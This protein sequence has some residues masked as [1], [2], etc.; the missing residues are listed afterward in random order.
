[1]AAL[2]ET[3]FSAR[4]LP[5]HGLGNVTE[6]VLTASEAIKESGLDWEVNLRP[7]YA[8][9]P[10]GKNRVKIEGK[11]AVMRDSDNAVFGIV[12]EKYKTFQNSEAFSF[13]D[14]LVDSGEAKYETAGALRD[15]KTIFITAKFPE[16]VLIG[17]E[18]PHEQY[19]FLTTTHDGTGS[20][21][22]M[23]TPI[24]VV[25]TN[26][27]TMALAGAA[28]KWSVPHTQTMKGR[29]AEARETLALSFEYMSEF[30]KR[31]EL[32]LRKRITDDAFHS[33]VSELFEPH[34]KDTEPA[35]EIVMDLYRNSPTNGFH[36][37]AWGG[38]NAFAEF[39]EHNHRQR[40]MEARLGAVMGWQEKFRARAAEALLSV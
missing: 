23:M 26:T 12:S 11:R 6:N 34:N 21:R 14:T 37:N 13:L 1:M 27:L 25:C 2:V 35:I 38:F 15:G 31:A 32:L 8:S 5:W 29:I 16:A 30:Q 4:E 18:D 39:F 9:L 28:N 17:K 3:M 20:V 10:G 22:V 7:V 40:S 24:R 36:G 33:I 19:L